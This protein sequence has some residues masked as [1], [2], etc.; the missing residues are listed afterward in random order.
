MKLLGILI[1]VALAVCAKLSSST[2]VGQT[3]ISQ[4]ETKNGTTGS[5]KSLDSNNTQ[6]LDGME[7]IGC[8]FKIGKGH[9]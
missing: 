3:T 4:A 2:P 6:V 8:S 5:T 7:R 9:G 1:I